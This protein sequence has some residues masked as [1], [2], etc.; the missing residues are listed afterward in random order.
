MG[1][2]DSAFF[3]ITILSEFCISIF[4]RKLC[5]PK[6][7]IYFHLFFG[8]VFCLVLYGKMFLYVFLGCL[9]SYVLL[10][11]PGFL[12][13]LASIP[14]ACGLIWVHFYKLF[15]AQDW[16]SDLSGLMMFSVLRVL[17]LSF[18]VFDGRKKEIK[19]KQWKDVSLPAPPNF[20]QYIS[21]LFGYNGLY[22]GPILP[23]KD[24]IR[25][26]NLESTNEEIYNDIKSGIPN[27]V[28]GVILLI[29]YII[30]VSIVPIS[31]ILSDE[32]QQINILLRFIISIVLSF[33]HTSRYIFAWVSAEAGW[34]ALGAAR[35]NEEYVSSI[36]LKVYFQT[37][38]LSLLPNEWNRSI[39]FILKEYFHVRL[40]SV[41][42][43]ASIAK[44]ATFAVSAA[45]HGFYSGFYVFALME[46]IFGILDNFR[47]KWF[48]PLLSTLFGEKISFTFDI[49]WVQCINYFL[50]APW[51]LFFAVYYFRFYRI[52]NYLPAILY[53]I[54]LPVGYIFRKKKSAK[55]E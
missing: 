34:R 49:V 26:C 19:R 8:I 28:S 13:L 48:T 12:C 4:I 44:F 1:V 18:N 42:V 43:P 51:D 20:M 24:F 10:Y 36:Q 54:I 7:R 31:Y 38:R 21:Y 50:G 5:V 33:V 15:H 29:I 14:P 27:Y 47:Y 2:L 46:V 9:L 52:M 17:S 53:A 23:F 30:G 39:H 6:N 3:G 40:I 22:T 41:G 37:R 55:T 35:V 32:F 45:W 11:L 16:K 25:T